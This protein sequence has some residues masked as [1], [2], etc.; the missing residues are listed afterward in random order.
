MQISLCNITDDN[1]GTLVMGRFEQDTDILGIDR[2][3]ILW[4]AVIAFKRCCEDKDLTPIQGIHH[5]FGVF[6]GEYK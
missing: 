5:G 3:F 6:G 1:A 2:Y 4:N